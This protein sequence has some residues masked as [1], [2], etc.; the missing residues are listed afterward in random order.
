MV[1]LTIISEIRCGAGWGVA[2]KD[3][4]THRLVRMGSLGISR[5]EDRVLKKVQAKFAR[6][7]NQSFQRRIELRVAF[8]V[9]SD[10]AIHRGD[11]SKSI[12]DNELL[13]TGGNIALSPGLFAIKPC[14]SHDAQDVARFYSWIALIIVTI[15]DSWSKRLTSSGRTNNDG[16]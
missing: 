6:A 11:F 15:N 5:L 4:W 16:R 9:R 7:V 14:T 13:S 2:W 3:A 10:C 1:I 8:W 12:K